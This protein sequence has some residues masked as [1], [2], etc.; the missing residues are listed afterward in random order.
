MGST[1]GV[2]GEENVKE[3]EEGEVQRWK[4]VPQRP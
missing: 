1:V 3:G 4:A 2:E